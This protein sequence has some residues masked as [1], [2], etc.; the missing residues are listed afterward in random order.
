VTHAGMQVVASML[1]YLG[2]AL[3]AAQHVQP[4][5]GSVTGPEMSNTGLKAEIGDHSSLATS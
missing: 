5:P 3:T 4:E 1:H 2:T